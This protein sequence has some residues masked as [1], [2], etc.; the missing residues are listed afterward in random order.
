MDKAPSKTADAEDGEIEDATSIKTKVEEHTHKPTD[1]VDELKVN[2]PQNNGLLTDQSQDPPKP[3]PSLEE[4]ASESVPEGSD[5]NLKPQGG[6]LR[7][8]MPALGPANSSVPMRPEVSRNSSFGQVNS[9]AHH[10]LPSR[11][12]IVANRTF[13]N[14]QSARMGDRPPD[15]QREARAPERALVDSPKEYGRERFHDRPLPSSQSHTP[16]RNDG[17]LRGTD[18]ERNERHGGDILPTMRIPNDERQDNSLYRDPRP[19]FR[20]RASLSSDSRSILDPNRARRDFHSNEQSERDAAMLPPRSTVS[21]HPDRAALIQGGSDGGRLGPSARPLDRRSEG[22]RYNDNPNSEQNSR[23]AS[24]TRTHDRPPPHEIRRGVERRQ[25]DGYR[26]MEEGQFPRSRYDDTYAPSGPRNDRTTSMAASS[27]NDRFRETARSSA[28][29]GPAHDFNHGRLNQDGPRSGWQNESQYGRLNAGND[30]PAGP[31]LSNGHNPH[32]TRGGRHTGLLPG[33]DGLQQ[34]PPT[35]SSTPSHSAPGKQNSNRPS[36]HNGANES[37]HPPFEGQVSPTAPTS[38]GTVD[39]GTV[40]PDRLKAIQGGG[41]AANSVPSD[42][43]ETN[44]G[45][46]NPPPLSVPPPTSA[47]GSLPSP[48]QQSPTGRGGPPP[49]GPAFAN[50][51]NR[52]KR[53][54]GIQNVLQQSNGPPPPDRSGQGTSIRGRGGRGPITPSG[55][56]PMPSHAPRDAGP[57]REDLFAGRMNGSLPSGPVEDDGA[58]GRGNRRGP[59]GRDAPQEVERKSTRHRSRSPK[60]DRSFDTPPSQYRERE[61]PAFREDSRENFREDETNYNI[62]SNGLPDRD[63]R[64][65]PGFPERDIRAGP[66]P[67]RSTREVAGDGRGGQEGG[68]D[69]RGEERRDGGGSMRKRGRGVEEMVVERPVDTKR[70]R[71]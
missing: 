61:R 5:P 57:A 67:R 38:G 30:T 66:P 59:P 45:P 18:R 1:Q 14:R 71:R 16:E 40:H 42:R 32:Y 58:Y 8:P 54:A 63:A 20:D 22:S 56:G 10:E 7:K 23:A 47:R 50:D 24:P 11:P 52:D 3:A 44:R 21:H 41:S 35:Q 17:R 19:P 43:V 62:R 46:R 60:A 70:P 64:R 65:P 55:N 4:K 34:T 13:D 12:E 25:E 31:R 36:P 49:S 9:R 6:P 15:H 37:S 29:G 39:V 28:S 26:T 27:P 2:V 48:I 33:H 69:R 51:R 68:Y 53:F